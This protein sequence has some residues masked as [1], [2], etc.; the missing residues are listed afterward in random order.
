MLEALQ[1]QP[2]SDVAAVLRN[3][4]V[5]ANSQPELTG[6]FSTFAA[7]TPQLYLD[8]DRN[9]A[10]TLGV[11][12]SDIFNALQTTLGSYY[13]NDFNLFGRTWQ[14]N[15]QAE[16]PYRQRVDDIYKIYVQNK[17]GEMVSMRTLADVRLILGP[18][19]SPATTTTA[20]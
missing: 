8:I 1:G 9:K 6:V 17:K 12:I 11:N 5:Q 4:V 7:N 3:L 19:M 15:V 13:V 18:Q 10:E 14:V 20:R 2:F 16:T